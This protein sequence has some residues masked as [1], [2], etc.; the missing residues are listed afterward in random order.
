MDDA[1]ATALRSVGEDGAYT[2]GRASHVVLNGQPPSDPEFL[3][4]DWVFRNPKP[5]TTRIRV[6]LPTRVLRV[7]LTKLRYARI[8]PVGSEI[9]AN[10]PYNTKKN[11]KYVTLGGTL[12]EDLRCVMRKRRSPDSSHPWC[13]LVDPGGF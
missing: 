13:N 6:V 1:F 2:V 12:S 9:A 3:H 4:Q 7:N 5:R 11:G 10:S 8:L